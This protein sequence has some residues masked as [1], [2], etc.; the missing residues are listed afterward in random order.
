MNGCVAA[1]M[2]GDRRVDVVCTG[3][4]ITRWYENLGAGTGTTSGR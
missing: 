4:G 3:G 2:N 1:D